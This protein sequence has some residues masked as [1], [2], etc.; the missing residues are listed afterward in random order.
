MQL[1]FKI[2]ATVWWTQTLLISAYF[3]H[4][5][6]CCYRNICYSVHHFAFNKYRDRN[7]II[8]NSPNGQS[9]WSGWEIHQAS[10]RGQQREIYELHH[11]HWLREL[12]THT[13]KQCHLHNCAWLQSLIRVLEI[14]SKSTIIA[15]KSWK[16]AGGVGEYKN[17]HTHS[18]SLTEQHT[19]NHKNTIS[20]FS[21]SADTHKHIAIM[22]LSDP[23]GGEMWYDEG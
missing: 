5:F 6:R 18:T 16:V 10:S 23:V 22:S 14:G 19:H 11:S 9:Q 20:P 1:K 17:A 7:S 4:P 8:I 12:H 21:L 15:C 13:W 2:T 3:I